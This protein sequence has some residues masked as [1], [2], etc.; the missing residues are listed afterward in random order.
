VTQAA[1]LH[2]SAQPLWGH[3]LAIWDTGKTIR[4]P[5]FAFALLRQRG[6]LIGNKAVLSPVIT[7]YFS[8]PSLHAITAPLKMLIGEDLNGPNTVVCRCKECREKTNVDDSRAS[9]Y[10]TRQIVREVT[11]HRRYQ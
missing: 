6:L 4:V 8:D 7:R 11:A 1:A 5:N 2:D 10:H 3:P 9:N